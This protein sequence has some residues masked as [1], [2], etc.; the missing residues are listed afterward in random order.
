VRYLDL[1]GQIQPLKIKPP[2]RVLAMISSPRDYPSLDVAGEWAKLEQAVDDLEQ[3]GRV[4]L[5]RLEDATL[6]ALQQRLRRGEY[7]IF[8]FI[9]H[10]IFDRRAED[11]M[12]LLEDEEGRGRPVSGQYMG[13]LL[14]D[15][16][17]LRLAI[18]NACEGAR[19]S[20][21]DPFAG[22]A[23][24]LVKQGTPAVI[25]M[26]FEI[27]DEAAIAFAYEFYGA[28]ADGYPADAALAEARKALFAQGNDVEWGTPVLYSR[29]S[30]GRIFDVE[31]MSEA[32][33]QEA[34]AQ[35]AEAK[36][37]SV[38][39]AGFPS[40]F[41]SELK[42]Q[43]IQASDPAQI[44]VQN[45]GNTEQTFTL[46]WQDR[47]RE[48]VFEPASA[49]LTVPEGE[50][51]AVEFRAAPRRVRWIGAAQEHSFSAHVA[52]SEGEV[53]THSGEVVSKG[54]VPAWVVPVLLF[55]CFCLVATAALA[56]KYF[57]DRSLHATQTAVAVQTAAAE[58]ERATTV[59]MTTQTAVA[60]Q[61]VAAER[62]RAT[63][64][65][66]T[67]QTAVAV[68]TAA[69]EQERA[70]T[71]VVT[72]QPSLVPT[73]PLPASID[74]PWN[75]AWK[76]LPE[77]WKQRLGHS[78]YQGERLTC[79]RQRFEGGFMFWCDR[80]RGRIWPEGWQGPNMIFA[81]EE[82]GGNRA[83]Y[84]EDTWT[85]YEDET[86]CTYDPPNLKGGFR[87]VW[88]ENEDVMRVLRLPL[89][90]EW[91]MHKVELTPYGWGPGIQEFEGGYMLWDTHTSR[92]WV[93]IEDFG[94]K[95]SPIGPGTV[96]PTPS[97]TPTTTPTPT[98]SST[99]TTTPTPT[100]SDTPTPKPRLAY[101]SISLA[102][103]ANSS[104]EPN[105]AD[106]EFGTFVAAGVPFEVTKEGS[107]TSQAVPFPEY[108]AR[109]ELPVE[110]PYPREVHL[111]MT[112]GDGFTE[113]SGEEIG[114]IT[115]HFSDEQPMEV[116]LILGENIREWKEAGLGT[117]N[118]TTDPA[119]QEVYREG[120]RIIDMLTIEIPSHLLSSTLVSIVISDVSESTCGS[121]SPAINVHGIT[122][123]VEQ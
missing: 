106:I 2:L 13:T 37:K 29:V 88:C 28:L 100:P 65:M 98:P 49:R 19:T 25:A 78:S 90:Y 56:A 14:Q 67:T 45:L 121:L 110:I 38:I 58:R 57:G 24:S 10:G 108:P 41:S 75:V 55:L 74:Q 83:W 80:Q 109:V 99:L 42:P 27:T 5:E 86:P 82:A 119:S 12:L 59:A 68:Q 115:L 102:S 105:Y 113:F 77:T 104:L 70:T 117:V 112:A 8:H 92:L 23:Q 120:V 34:L 32:E 31:P 103:I 9:G 96:T 26:Q 7:H 64:V 63:T 72:P 66:M 16:R 33:Q 35:I 95:S 52:S 107:F 116:K 36:E 47:A 122:I 39:E 43:R 46:T 111:L 84:M 44:T 71:V 61:T 6:S 97:A 93:L 50:S 85:A 3:R 20:R 81:V 62:E 114:Q 79:V 51:A 101:K 123:L 15:E 94:W 22:T 60:V 17:T 11:G 118:S 18:L 48:L 1:P 53:Q 21:T 73:A 40:R 30:S 69:A 4:I 54:L 89:E 91:E 76:N 87:K